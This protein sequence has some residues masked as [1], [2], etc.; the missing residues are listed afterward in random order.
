MPAPKPPPAPPPL[1]EEPP[2]S[3]MEL[4]AADTAS[5]TSLPTLSG[6]MSKWLRG[7]F[8]LGSLLAL[9]VLESSVGGGGGVLLP[10]TLGLGGSSSGFLPHGAS[11]HLKSVNAALPAATGGGGGGAPRR[12]SVYPDPIAAH[13]AEPQIFLVWTK[14]MSHWTWVFMAVVESILKFHPASHVTFYSTAGMMPLDFFACLSQE[15][16]DIRVVHYDLKNMSR[17]TLVEGL[18]DSGK[19]QGSKYRY[20]HES[21]LVRILVLKERGGTYTDTDTLFLRRMDEYVLER[22]SLGLE[23]MSKRV[24]HFHDAASTRLN[25]A[26]INLPLPGHPFL[27]CMMA[28]IAPNYDPGEWAAIGPDLVTKCHGGLTGEWAAN[29]RILE[30]MCLYPV[31]WKWAWWV[32]SVF[33]RE[34]I[35][36]LWPPGEREYT[37]G[38]HLYNSNSWNLVAAWRDRGKTDEGDMDKWVDPGAKEGGYDIMYGPLPGSVLADLVKAARLEESVYTGRKPAC[39]HLRHKG[40]VKKEA[41]AGAPAPAAGAAAGAAAGE[42]TA[43]AAPA[44]PPAV[45]AA[46]AGAGEATT[47]TP[48]SS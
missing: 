5:L 35:E 34:G 20:A 44:A 27:D 47:S 28:N 7:L 6:R 43:Q 29:F 13:V 11:Q 25:N 37:Y 22:P 32:G 19:I 40:G 21:D 24:D 45:I 1:A 14:D 10:S 23:T 42:G 15:G 26:F 3:L 30:P 4:S 9:L 38:I 16:Y 39:E 46:T 41:G 48:S 8:L 36:L 33:R 12:G 31:D 17:G 2:K 18:V